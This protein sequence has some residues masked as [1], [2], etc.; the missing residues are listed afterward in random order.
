MDGISTI[1]T[2]QKIS[3][4]KTLEALWKGIKIKE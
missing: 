2:E 1:E 3:T 4:I